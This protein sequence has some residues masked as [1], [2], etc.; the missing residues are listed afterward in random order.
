MWYY[1]C[2]SVMVRCYWPHSISITWI[3]WLCDI[4]DIDCLLKQILY[5]RLNRGN[6]I[7]DN[8]HVVVQLVCIQT[9]NRKTNR[10]QKSYSVMR[11]HRMFIIARDLLLCTPVTCGHSFLPCFP[12][13]SKHD[14]P[15]VESYSRTSHWH[16]S[17][18]VR[19]W[20]YSSRRLHYLTESYVVFFHVRHARVYP[21]V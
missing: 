18:C 12:N 13:P 6:Y 4:L 7:S 20:Y 10:I 14:R 9:G 17:L 3:S 8:K 21:L 1:I 19:L 5:G 16:I 15:L 2:H 11:F